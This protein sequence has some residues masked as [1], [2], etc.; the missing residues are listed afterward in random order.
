MSELRQMSTTGNLDHPIY[1]GSINS[2]D[3]GT[4]SSPIFLLLAQ[5][6]RIKNF[7]VELDCISGTHRVEA[8]NF[9]VGRLKLN[10][11]DPNAKWDTW[12]NGDIVSP[13]MSSSRLAPITAI[14]IYTTVEGEA[15][16]YCRGQ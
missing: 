5:D 6:S 9:P 7:V 2:L 11:D 12:N 4:G 3:S 15:I 16:V 1:E 13:A 14:R 8:T 10:P